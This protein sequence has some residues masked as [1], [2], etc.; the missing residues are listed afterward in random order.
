[1]RV[2]GCGSPD[3]GDDAAGLRVAELLEPRFE[4]EGAV[5]VVRAPAGAHLLDLMEDADAVVV[6]DA[7]RTYGASRTP[8]TI[9]RLEPGAEGGPEA[10]A[11]EPAGSLSSHGFGVAEALAM[12]RVLGRAARVVLFGVEAGGT[13]VGAPATPAVERAIPLLAE[14]VRTEVGLLREE[15]AG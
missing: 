7:V 3:G 4:R 8:G 13:E 5:E 14:M 10:S 9:V 2:V 11:V 1:V 12:A 6:V 15:V